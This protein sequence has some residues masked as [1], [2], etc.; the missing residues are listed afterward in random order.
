MGE[1]KTPQWHYAPPS[2]LSL[3]TDVFWYVILDIKKRMSLVT[4]SLLQCHQMLTSCNSGIANY[5]LGMAFCGLKLTERPGAGRG[6]IGTPGRA[7][8]RAETMMS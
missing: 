7:A 5:M 8:G 6:L 1:G 2:H 4:L 3:L